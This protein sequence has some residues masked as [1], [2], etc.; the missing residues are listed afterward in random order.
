MNTNLGFE[1]TL[2]AVGDRKVCHPPMRERLLDL[3]VCPRCQGPLRMEAKDVVDGEIMEGHLSCGVCS[4]TYPIARGIPRLV[5]QEDIPEEAQVNVDRFGEQWEQFDTLGDHYEAQFLGWIHP[6]PPETFAGK[7]VLEAG[8]GKGRH[9]A[10]V[11]KWGAKD[12]LATDLGPSVET[13]FRNTRSYPNVHVIQANLFQLPVQQGSVDIGFSVGVLHHTP[14]P[15]LGFLSLRSKVRPGGKVIAWVY[16]R[17]NNGWIVH[18]VDAFRKNVSSRLPFRV[19]YELAKLPAAVLVGLGRGVY[20]PLSKGTLRVVGDRLFYHQYM[21]QLARFPF[22]EVHTIVHDH[23]TPTIAHYI[24][25]PDFRSWF[26]EAQLTDIVVGWH[27]QNSWRGTGI[28]PVLSPHG[29]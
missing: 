21:R 22:S 27:N 23:L 13:A 16:G 19:V 1:F 2:C 15:K 11:A 24:P 6:N 18:G 25:G 17:E 26:D 8:C 28:V 14:D 4:S 7:T 12:V 20:A 10:L 9:S 29:A 5:L 3:I